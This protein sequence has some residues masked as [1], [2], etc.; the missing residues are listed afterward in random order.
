[1]PHPRALPAALLLLLVLATT[2]PVLA[3]GPEPDSEPAE[4]L[5]P[6]EDPPEG[7]EFVVRHGSG[8]T[9]VGGT[10]RVARGEVQDGD[11]TVV[12][13][14]AIIDG[15]VRGNVTVVLGNLNVRGRVEGEVVGVM[16]RMRLDDDA[17]IG[18]NL[19]SVGGTL[20]AADARIGGETVNIGIG[21]LSV[22]GSLFV[23]FKTLELLLVFVTMLVLAA[24]VPDRI[25]T[26]AG[27]VPVGLVGSFFLGVAG[28]LGLMVGL[29]LMFLTLLGIPLIP[30]A[31]CVF[32]VLKCLAL[33]GIF[34]FVGLRLGRSF[35]REMSLL[36]SI[37]LGFLPFAL[38]RFVP[39]LGWWAV[40]MPLQLVAVGLLIR[41]RAGGRSAVPQAPVVATT[42]APAPAP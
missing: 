41:T 8:R 25:R 3:Q 23:F 21:P 9:S 32:F 33:A 28:Y 26:I 7:E 2:V 30:L 15:T 27:E 6:E 10:I 13:G 19:T 14:N 42:A 18:G 4:D 36:G 24:L 34:H 22:A 20:D 16:T 37:L 39:L 35:G 11:V 12:W 38:L 1:M 40:W 17:R 31:W 5:L 29:A